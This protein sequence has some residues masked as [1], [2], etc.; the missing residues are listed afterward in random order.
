MLRAVARSAGRR[1]TSWSTAP[2]TSTARERAGGTLAPS[3]ISTVPGPTTSA[4]PSRRPSRTTHRRASPREGTRNTRGARI[5]IPH[6]R[7]PR[8]TPSPRRFAPSRR[9]GR[10]LP[11]HAPARPTGGTKPRGDHGPGR[12]STHHVQT[13]RDQPRKRPIE[14]LRSTRS[15]YHRSRDGTDAR[16]RVRRRA[17]GHVRRRR[18]GV[19]LRRRRRATGVERNR[20]RDD[21]D[22]DVTRR[23]SF[24]ARF[25]PGAIRS[26]RDDRTYAAMFA[27][28]FYAGVVQIRKYKMRP[29]PDFRARSRI[30]PAPARTTRDPSLESVRARSSS[31]TDRFTV[32]TPMWTRSTSG[33]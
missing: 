7:N 9:R 6:P 5:A 11:T 17:R 19:A 1:V 22:D 2:S 16:L 28:S 32:C 33:P 3:P 14:T 10:R 23:D 30:P 21:T 26:R 31:I 13:P 4:P 20:A 8:P 29:P 18:R 15:T 27:W 24:Q 12:P 25:V